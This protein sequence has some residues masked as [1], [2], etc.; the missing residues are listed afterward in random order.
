MGITLTSSSVAYLLQESSTSREHVTLSLPHG[1]VWRS[2][3]WHTECLLSTVGW[4]GRG[5]TGCHARSVPPSAGWR[6]WNAARGPHYRQCSSVPSL[7][8]H[9]QTAGR[10]KDAGKSLIGKHYHPSEIKDATS[11]PTG[12]TNQSYSMAKKIKGADGLC[13]LTTWFRIHRLARQW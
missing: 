6:W 10:R 3:R 7:G 12:L 9:K 2:P 8:L 5:D 1:R 11:W 13:L 4:P